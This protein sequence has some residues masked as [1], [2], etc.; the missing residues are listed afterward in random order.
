MLPKPPPPPGCISFLPHVVNQGSALANRDTLFALGSDF[1]AQITPFASRTF[2][3]T[4]EQ[5]GQSEDKVRSP[6]ADGLSA[7][8]R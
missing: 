2:Q 1:G 6:F 4:K 7:I 5:F 3:Y 8:I